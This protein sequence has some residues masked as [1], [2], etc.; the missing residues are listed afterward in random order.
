MNNFKLTKNSIRWVVSI[1]RC[2]E[3]II[4]LVLPHYVHKF[5]EKKQNPPSQKQMS[6][7]DEAEA[8]RLSLAPADIVVCTTSEDGTYYYCK[9]RII[10]QGRPNIYPHEISL[11]E[12][13]INRSSGPFHDLQEFFSL[14]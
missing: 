8:V 5:D 7:E 6:R 11:Y 2:I 10:G 4:E 3:L 12:E 14:A 1:P 13:I 9:K